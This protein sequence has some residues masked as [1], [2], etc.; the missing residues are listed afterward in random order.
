MSLIEDEFGAALHPG[1]K[2][3][4]NKTGGLK[5]T[6]GR[7]AR[8]A[9]EVMVKITGFGKGADHVKAHLD[10]VS[11][12]G[13][14]ELENDRGEV[15]EGKEAV[16]ALF[17]EWRED[18]GDSKRHKNQ[19]DTMHVVLSMP[20][21][22]ESEAVRA[23]VRQFAKTTFGKNHEY[24]FALHT[25]APHPHCHLTVKCRGF[26]GRMLHVAKGDP[27]V[28][29]E[30]F[31]LA[32]R[33]QGEDAEATPRR[34]RGVVKKREKAVIRHI[35]RGDT[36]HAPRVSKVRAAQV[37]QMADELTAEAHG[38]QQP[39]RLWETKI[40][41]R[42]A[43]IR[44]A[45]LSAA[46]AL[47][48]SPGKEHRNAR[49]DYDRIDPERVRRGHRAAALYQ[50][51]LAKSHARRAPR[52]VA[53]LRNLSGLSVVHQQGA[54][55][56]LLLKNA[57]DRL[58]RLDTGRDDV[59][60]AGTGPDRANATRTTRLDA[61]LSPTLSDAE[62]AAKIRAFVA[63]M[64]PVL[65]AR[66]ERKGELLQRFGKARERAPMQIADTPAQEQRKGAERAAPK[67]GRDG[68][69]R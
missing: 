53:S 48:Q 13:K 42:Q 40:Q 56:M 44:S 12:N 47:E 33:D 49:P 60:R 17:N 51:H 26:D 6:A 24:V 18:F 22:T 65:T 62:L 11:R 5:S 55:Q 2:R 35:E 36:T 67:P 37:K 25:D 27:Q 38:G 8:G 32:L 14:V 3:K 61:V 16:K 21:S 9:P 50:S 19:R 64:P 66:D 58:G 59:R 7:V 10:Y 68:A 46:K 34:S 31:A 1:V 63:R 43:A 57:P 23:A 45:W 28:W 54:A 4:A 52:P 69:E 30:D 20:E 41:T 39:A 15:F 29:R